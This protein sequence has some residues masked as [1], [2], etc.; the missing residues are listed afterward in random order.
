MLQLNRRMK[1]VLW[2]FAASNRVAYRA[3][4]P[5]L[6]AWTCGC[7]AAGGLI[8]QAVVPACLA[9]LAILFAASVVMT[10]A[11]VALGVFPL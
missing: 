6:I 2:A 11:C 4:S 7:V 1:F 9:V 10:F 3:P 8:G 5:L